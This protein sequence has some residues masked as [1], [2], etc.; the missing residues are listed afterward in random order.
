V[1]Q[2]QRIQILYKKKT[3]SNRNGKKK[4]VPVS[5]RQ[6]PFCRIHNREAEAEVNSWAEIEGSK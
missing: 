5:E 6:L 4:T 2:H 3:P 1:D